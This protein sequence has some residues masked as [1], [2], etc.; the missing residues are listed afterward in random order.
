[1]KTEEPLIPSTVNIVMSNIT[2]ILSEDLLTIFLIN[3]TQGRNITDYQNN[4]HVTN[5]NN[6]LLSLRYMVQEYLLGGLTTTKPIQTWFDGY[7]AD[8]FD[9]ISD[10]DFYQG[11]DKDLI[12][13][14]NPIS[15]LATP[16]VKNAEIRIDT[17]AL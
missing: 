6:F 14:I 7:D 13:K 12:K 9:M 16:Q 11:N 1:M 4:L 8:F 17:G 10:G 15:N 2:G 3:V 5:I